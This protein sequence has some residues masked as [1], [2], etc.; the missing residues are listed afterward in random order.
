M[1]DQQ[2]EQPAPS[3]RASH[4]PWNVTLG[5]GGGYAPRFEGA[6][7]Y[8]VVPVPFASVSYAGMGSVGPEGFSANILRSGGFRAGL[9]VGYSGGRDESDDPHLRG[10][11]DISTA[12]QMGGFVAYQWSAF[13]IRGQIRQAVT[14]SGNGLEG[15]L[16]VN[17]M[18]RPTA[19]WM[20]K[21]GPQLVFADSDY[22]KKYFG[23]TAVQSHNSGLHAY[24]ARGGLK[25]VAFGLNTTY[26]LSEHWLL[27]GIAKVSEIIG[28][29]AD[30]PV[31]QTK[32]QAFT[33][34]GL[35]YHF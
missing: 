8:H 11:G 34:A 30:S 15:S 31:V 35:A 17:Y 5:L 27:F 18:M 3:D 20:V 6:D 9:L 16:G 1:V 19:A 2:L 33:G 14:H 26:Q 22:M 12:V 10:L 28:D 32:E 24:T 23:I 25:D 7:R 21:L 13:E 4:G 29:A